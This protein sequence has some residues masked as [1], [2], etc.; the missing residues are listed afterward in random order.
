M[1]WFGSVCDMECEKRKTM[2]FD[3]VLKS[4]ESRR[5][6]VLTTCPGA[7]FHIN[8][9]VNGVNEFIAYDETGNTII[10]KETHWVR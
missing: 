7:R 4:F 9:N 10:A 6:A 5:N 2:A 3:N 1:S 8:H